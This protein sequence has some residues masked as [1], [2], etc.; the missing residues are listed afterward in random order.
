MHETGRMEFYDTISGFTAT[1][2]LHAPPGMHAPI[3]RTAAP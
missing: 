1:S 2:V 3:P